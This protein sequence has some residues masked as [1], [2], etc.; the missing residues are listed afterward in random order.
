MK[1][2]LLFVTPRLERVIQSGG[3]Q[4]TNER[5]DGLLPH[6]NVSVLTLEGS[7]STGTLV[8]KVNVHASGALRPRK[9]SGLLQSYLK[10]LPLSVWRNSPPDFLHVA[11]SLSRSHWDIVYA[12]HWLVWEAARRIRA[13][14][15]ILHLHNAEPELFFRAAEDLHGS[16][17]AISTLEGWRAARYIRQ[18]V[19]HIDEL[20]LLSHGDAEALR[21]RGVSHPNSKVFLPRLLSTD[22]AVQTPM[23]SKQALFVGSLNWL[24]NA[25]G[26]QWFRQEVLPLLGAEVR[27]V[28]AGGGASDD[29]NDSFARCHSVRLTGYVDDLNPL[30]QS[31]R[32]LIAPLLSGSGIK[33]KVVN[34]L[35]RGVPVVTTSVGAEG[36][37]RDWSNSIVVADDP[38]K[39][40]DAVRRLMDDDARW[41]KA[42]NEAVAY[43]ERHF[44]G[45]EWESW[46]EAEGR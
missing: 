29:F 10:R 2:K 20:H 32:C 31:S 19:P 15:R 7:S 36:F 22:H 28:V 25:Q 18:L 1:K 17:R 34:A 44:S 37:P 30:Y 40:A 39:F 3:L 6:F 45:R 38:L 13:R 4:V 24:P 43:S 12:D 33:I 23:P 14:K 5:L 11:T 9:V 42:S 41:K 46:C 8:E 16:A 26:M 27:V 35:S 21:A